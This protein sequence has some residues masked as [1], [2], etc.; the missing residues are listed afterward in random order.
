ML[1][2]LFQYSNDT[3]DL[4]IENKKGVNEMKKLTMNEIAEKMAN[5]LTVEQL[6]TAIKNVLEGKQ[7]K[8]ATVEFRLS[9]SVAMSCPEDE[10]DNDQAI[11]LA[12]EMLKDYKKVEEMVANM[13][14][15]VIEWS[16]NE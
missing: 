2:F 1:L 3:I 14:A 13:T 8:T 7:M 9:V 5:E 11:Y 10:L 15:E 12:F 4:N 16:E 6:D